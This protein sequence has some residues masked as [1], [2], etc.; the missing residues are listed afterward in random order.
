VRQRGMARG[1][2]AVGEHAAAS[3]L[4]RSSPPRLGHRREVVGQGGAMRSSPQQW[5]DSEGAGGGW[6][7]L[8][9]WSSGDG[10]ASGGDGGGG[11]VL[12]HREANR[13]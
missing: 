3:R 2:R 6:V 8:R 1:H 10:S 13:A 9:R 12:E 5:I 11:D 4:T 7:R